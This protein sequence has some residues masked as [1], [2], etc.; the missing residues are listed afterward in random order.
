MSQHHPQ[1][2][3]QPWQQQNP[4]TWQ[5]NPPP[6][7][8]GPTGLLTLH[9]KPVPGLLSKEMTTAKV[10]IDGYPVPVQWGDNAIPVPTGARRVHIRTGYLY[11]YGGAEQIVEIAPGQRVDLFYATPAAA[12]L[13]GSLGTEPQ[14][15]RGFVAMIAILVGLV[16]AAI[17]FAVIMALVAS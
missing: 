2:N 15:N 8:A 4:Q 14:K 11:D 1:Q 12:F 5:Q 9:L 7:T 16:L 3:T 6:P 13:T 10:T 17:L